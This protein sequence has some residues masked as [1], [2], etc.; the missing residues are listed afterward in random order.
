[1]N[2]EILD[3]FNSPNDVRWIVLG[4]E[5]VAWMGMRIVKHYL[6]N[7]QH[8][9]ILDESG[10]MV[11]FASGQPNNTRQYLQ[12]QTI[13]EGDEWQVVLL[14]ECLYYGSLDGHCNL[15]A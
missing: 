8:A 9:H 2:E 7:N 1:L 14:Q 5:L 15:A 6:P 11:L 10:V 4:L 12:L 13:V 3:R